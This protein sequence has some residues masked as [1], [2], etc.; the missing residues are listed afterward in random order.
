M[1]TPDT[2][3]TL[4]TP[5]FPGCFFTL[6][7]LAHMPSEVGAQARPHIEGVNQVFWHLCGISGLPGTWIGHPKNC[8]EPFISHFKTS[9]HL[10]QLFRRTLLRHFP[11]NLPKCFVDCNSSYLCKPTLKCWV[12]LS[13]KLRH[14]IVLIMTKKTPNWFL[15]IRRVEK[16]KQRVE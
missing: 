9:R 10:L 5:R 14:W 7:V 16:R 8:T 3:L 12:N 15:L 11:V 2:T 4:L 13:S 1:G 6:K